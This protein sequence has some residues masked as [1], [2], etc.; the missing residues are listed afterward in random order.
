MKEQILELRKEGKSYNEIVKIVGCSKSTVAYHCNNTTKQKASIARDKHRKKKH[1][2]SRKVEKFKGRKERKIKPKK[3]FDKGISDKIKDF[4]RRQKRGNNNRKTTS[5]FTTYDVLIKF[6]ENPTCY[7]TGDSINL[8]DRDSYQLDHI[9]PFCKGGDNSLENLGL[10]TKQA[11]QMKSDMTLE[12]MYEVCE[13]ILR[14]K[15]K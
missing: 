6:G 1:P 15:D 12:E 11:N 9:I 8:H 4:K 7:L 2:I 14:H 5:S 10:C 3:L 13:K